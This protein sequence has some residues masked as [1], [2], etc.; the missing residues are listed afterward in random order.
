MEKSYCSLFDIKKQQNIF[1]YSIK[2][3]QNTTSTTPIQSFDA[4][5]P[6]SL[7]LLVLGK[8]MYNA[9]LGEFQLEKYIFTLFIQKYWQS[10]LNCPPTD[11]LRIQTVKYTYGNYKTT[12]PV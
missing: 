6:I 5:N 9:N 10:K 1:S 11:N 3:R 2:Q 12:F 4:F 7:K 8:V